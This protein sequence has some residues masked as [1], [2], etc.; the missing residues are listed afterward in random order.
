[1]TRSLDLAINAAT[2]LPPSEQDVLA[3]LL[4]DEIQSEQQWTQ[5]LDS[6]QGLLESLAQEALAEFAAGKTQPLQDSL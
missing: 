4:M 3:H 1:M 6:S 5:L 2:R